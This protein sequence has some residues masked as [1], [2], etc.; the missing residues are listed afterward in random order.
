MTLQKSYANEERRRPPRPAQSA[1]H[2]SPD[3]AT[4]LDFD[5]APASIRVNAVSGG[6]LTGEGR[7][8]DTLRLTVQISGRTSPGGR[9]P[10]GGRG[11]GG[12]QPPCWRGSGETSSPPGLP[13]PYAPPRRTWPPSAAPAGGPFVVIEQP[14]E[15]TVPF[16]HC[17]KAA[18]HE[19]FHPTTKTNCGRWW[20][21]IPPTGW[22]YAAS[23]RRGHEQAGAE[24]MAG[25]YQKNWEEILAFYY[26]GMTPD[27]L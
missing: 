9:R 18:G 22:R 3:E 10:A 16:F 25:R 12:S 8:M 7:R 1:G 17:G 14:F 15:V 4:G 2:R 23:A 24:W 26:P 21:R 5:P 19:H 6:R 27:A 20:K 13:L 11:S